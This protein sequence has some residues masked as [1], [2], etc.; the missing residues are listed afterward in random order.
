[1]R[2]E[3]NYSYSKQLAA[4]LRFW[5][6]LVREGLCSH[7]VYL[8]NLTL[9]GLEGTGRENSLRLTNIRANRFAPVSRRSRNGAAYL[10]RRVSYCPIH[11]G[12]GKMG[13]HFLL[14]NPSG[15]LDA[16]DANLGW[17]LGN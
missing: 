10:A 2:D 13:V 5:W 11:V 8:Y 6:E 15:D 7:K 12:K 3:K 9:G 16:Q 4:K 17:K 14:H 1:V